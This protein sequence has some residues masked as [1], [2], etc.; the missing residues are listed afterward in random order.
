MEWFD[1]EGD[2]ID[3]D[4]YGVDGTSDQIA[5]IFLKKSISM[6]F[7]AKIEEFMLDRPEILKLPETRYH[8]LKE[9]KIKHRLF[10][11]R[12]DTQN[13]CSNT[14]N[15]Q[16]SSEELNYS[17]NK[18]GSDSGLE[19]DSMVNNNSTISHNQF[20]PKCMPFNQ[21]TLSERMKFKK[22]KAKKLLEKKQHRDPSDSIFYLKPKLSETP[23]FEFSSS[24]GLT[25]KELKMLRNR[26]SAQR[27][28]DRKKKEFDELKLISQGIINENQYLKKELERKTKE[29]NELKESYSKLCGNCQ[30]NLPQ[31]PHI[32]EGRSNVASKLKYSL[33]AGFL[34]V[35][36]IL[37]TLSYSSIMDQDLQ[38][39]T[40]RVLVQ[41]VNTTSIEN[42]TQ[43]S[44][45]IKTNLSN[46]TD[47]IPFVKEIEVFK[48]NYPFKISKDVDRLRQKEFLGKKRYEFLFRINNNRNKLMKSENFLQDDIDLSTTCPNTDTL[49]ISVQEELVETDSS[50]NIVLKS[51]NDYY[52]NLSQD[53]FL[54]NHI[55]SMYCRDF[56]TN[57]EEDAK[58]FSSLFNKVNNETDL[59]K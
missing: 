23:E 50:K 48:P 11:V 12:H 13:K 36:C 8:D 10:D 30:K 17:E 52:V 39:Q 35:V 44:T 3:Q 14:P 28:R 32:S 51:N 5:D 18:E 34:A 46:K 20:V 53:T 4:M 54:R 45:P 47:I 58:M 22:E 43:V 33:M 42:G 38:Q 49:S 6:D 2:Y 29:I 21:M 25:K 26:M 31:R 55:K 19:C 7:D 27:S 57:A 41:Q 9:P 40:P 59:D 16:L 37:G 1:R 56:I 15:T 24:T